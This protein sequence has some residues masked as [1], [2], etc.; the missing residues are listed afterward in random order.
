MTAAVH[1]SSPRNG[2]SVAGLA[3]T[4]TDGTTV[5]A[6]A[7]LLTMAAMGRAVG[8]RCDE[9]PARPGEL[10]GC[11]QPAVTTLATDFGTVGCCAEGAR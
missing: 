4:R 8:M 10:C 2:A 1:R 11:G 3:P 5:V 7:P 9:Q 6:H